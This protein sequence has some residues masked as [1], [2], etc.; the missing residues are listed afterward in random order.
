MEGRAKRRKN[1]K[2][3]QKTMNESEQWQPPRALGAVDWASKK[4]LRHCG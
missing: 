4:T 1:Q 2:Q 3:Q